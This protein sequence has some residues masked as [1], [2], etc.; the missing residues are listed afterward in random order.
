MRKAE[1]PLLNFFL[2]EAEEVL[3]DYGYVPEDEVSEGDST[4]RD[5]MTYNVVM[6]GR[7]PLIDEE[8]GKD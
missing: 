1:D 5:W 7:V 6:T 3:E 8:R 2:N 4:F